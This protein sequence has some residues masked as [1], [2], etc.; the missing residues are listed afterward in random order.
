MTLFAMLGKDA[1][2]EKIIRFIHS[3]EPTPLWNDWYVGITND[4]TRRLYEEHRAP[5]NKSIYVS[6]DSAATA[7]SVGRF[8]VNSYGMDGRA[9]GAEFPRFVYAFRK[10]PDT[11][12]PL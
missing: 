9:D 1:A 4:V 2:I 3:T 6:V 10:L 8:L 7:R 5:Y 12:P 11:D